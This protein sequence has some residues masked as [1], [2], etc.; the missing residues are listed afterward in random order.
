[1]SATLYGHHQQNPYQN[2]QQYGQ[3]QY[4]QQQQ[5]PQQQQQ[6]PQLSNPGTA[7]QTH[8][9]TMHPNQFHLKG[10]SDASNPLSSAPSAA[11]TPVQTNPS[12]SSHNNLLTECQN[13]LQALNQ[14]DMGLHDQLATINSTLA[15]AALQSQQLRQ[16]QNSQHA[17]LQGVR[18]DVQILKKQSD[19]TLHALSLMDKRIQAML[20]LQ[21]EHSKATISLAKELGPKRSSVSSV[22]SP[23][24][25]TSAAVG[26]NGSILSDTLLATAASVAER[27]NSIANAT[28]A[29]GAAAMPNDY[30]PDMDAQVPPGSAQASVSAP[31]SASVSTDPHRLGL[32]SMSLGLVLGP[33]ASSDLGLGGLGSK[34][35]GDG[36]SRSGSGN[37][38][39]GNSDESTNHNTTRSHSTGFLQRHNSLQH[40]PTLS[41]SSLPNGPGLHAGHRS[42]IDGDALGSLNMLP[43]P[44]TQLQPRS[45]SVFDGGGG[46]GSSSLSGGLLRGD[47]RGGDPVAA[48]A[49]NNNKN[50]DSNTS[51]TAG[52]ATTAA[53]AANA[54]PATST[55]ASSGTS[56]ALSLYSIHSQPQQQQSSS[57]NSN[58][59]SLEH[60]T[61]HLS[62][63]THDPADHD[64]DLDDPELMSLDASHFSDPFRH[65][66][67][68]S[69][70]QQQQQ[71]TQLP[72]P[73][74]LHLAQESHPFAPHQLSQSHYNIH[75][76]SLAQLQQ[77]QQQLQPA[78]N[79]PQQAQH[80]P[81]RHNSS[82]S[83]QV[84]ATSNSTVESAATSNTLST[85]SSSSRSEGSLSSSSS[86]S[87][88]AKRKAPSMSLSEL[89]KS[90]DHHHHHELLGHKSANTNGSA[91]GVENGGLHNHLLVG[92]NMAAPMGRKRS[93]VAED[94]GRKPPTPAKR[95]RRGR[96][97]GRLNNTSMAAAA[98]AVA[99]ANAASSP[100]S[101][102][103][104]MSG[105][106]SRMVSTGSNSMSNGSLAEGVGM[107]DLDALASGLSEGEDS[108]DDD[109]DDEYSDDAKGA[110]AGQL[111]GEPGGSSS[112]SLTTPATRRR[113][114]KDSAH[115][116]NVTRGMA[117]KPDARYFELRIEEIKTLKT[118]KEAYVEFT[119]GIRG[120]PSIKDQEAYLRAT[121]G[122]H[123]FI[124]LKQA[125]S[126]RR[127]KTLITLI[128]KI[129]LHHQC[130]L[131]EAC[132]KL[133]A[134]RA[135][136]KKT[137]SW[138]CN[139]LP[140]V[141]EL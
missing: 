84:S 32:S 53:A 23:T 83:P 65:P 104:S 112:S 126:F 72:L 122:T 66:Q 43:S 40:T 61:H 130:G 129:R 45:H 52:P 7:S 109:D 39:N 90:E 29:M 38:I 87:S 75:I 131:D 33:D 55:T 50:S 125:R 71:H 57:S 12:S 138:V 25:T 41:S 114:A 26:P 18:S 19:K 95:G 68:Q 28:V 108:E 36:S 63:H 78:K 30:S 27:L 11:D 140:P 118:F 124:Q 67:Q 9:Q 133:E 44:R 46:D 74:S 137:I 81:Q 35:M 135:Q 4:Q 121:F 136:S 120:K 97:P 123:Y 62:S 60:L 15:A 48:T 111:D 94:L 31:V 24:V 77:Q 141:N 58:P 134:F 79:G 101:S 49:N 3:Y 59:Q 13:L 54:A 80:L 8:F 2:S 92:E 73:H 106:Q 105:P 113:D 116:R 98:A 127:R 20:R 100:R 96:P 64:I 76:P 6:L 102:I 91:A 5:Q 69:S 88:S 99:G 115:H 14:R 110:R 93:S 107:L 16:Y 119:E 85:N 21:Y 82:L 89:I 56:G 17:D 37:I 139:H 42:S 47:E 103:S 128:D 1:M 34:N 10:P 70:Q 132:A 86:S 51:G 117:S 22:S